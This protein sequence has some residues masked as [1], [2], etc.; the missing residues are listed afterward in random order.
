VRRVHERVQALLGD[1]IRLGFG[2]GG[3]RDGARLFALED[4]LREARRLQHV[5]ERVHGQF[6]FGLGGQGP[7]SEAGAIEVEVVA[8][9]CA[10]IG[11]SP[12]HV[13]FGKTRGAAFQQ[14]ECELA[15]AGA[16]AWVVRASRRE[17]DRDIDDRQSVSFDEIR[18]HAR[19]RCPMLDLHTRF[20]RQGRSQKQQCHGS[21]QC[22][23]HG[24]WAAGAA[25]AGTLRARLWS[26]TAT[27]EAV[28]DEILR[29]DA[30]DLFGRDRLQNRSG[31]RSA[32]RRDK[33][34]LDSSSPI[35]I[36]TGRRNLCGT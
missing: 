5:G 13:G 28:V 6:A 20:R 22:A 36:R 3:V 27:V 16:L 19:L 25:C 34:A 21:W 24:Q 4:L 29:G 7:Q 8:Q 12:V 35:S 23:I 18:P 2:L 26:R 14:S 15:Q 9:L 10:R 17:L 32:S 30:L 31:M 33:A 11:D 1:V